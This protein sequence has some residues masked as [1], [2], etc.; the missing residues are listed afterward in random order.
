[1]KKNKNISEEMAKQLQYQLNF[2]NPVKIDENKFHVY[3]TEIE[4]KKSG[5]LPNSYCGIP[6]EYHLYDSN[7]HV[8]EDRNS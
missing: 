2:K 4:L 3:Y 6:I 7:Y 1:M 8:L 5:I